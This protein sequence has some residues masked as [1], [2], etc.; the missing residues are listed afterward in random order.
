M[1]I[2]LS[3]SDSNKTYLKYH[4]LILFFIEMFIG[5]FVEVS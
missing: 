5:Q 3:L 2:C 1:V 4:S